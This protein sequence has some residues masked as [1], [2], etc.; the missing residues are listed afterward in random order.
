MPGFGDSAQ[1]F[2]EHG[3]LGVD[4]GFV[5][6]LTGGVEFLVGDLEEFGEVDFLGAFADEAAVK[7][8]FGGVAFFLDEAFEPQVNGA[9]ADDD[10]DV[11]GFLAGHA[12]DAVDGLDEFVVGPGVG[13]ED[14]V[15][16]QVKAVA[17]GHALDAGEHDGS[18]FV[19][20]VAPFLE[21]G[22]VDAAFFL[23]DAAVQLDVADPGV[24][25][26]AGQVIERIVEGAKH[27][28]LFLAGEDFFDEGEATGHFGDVRLAGAGRQGQF[29]VTVALDA[30]R[31]GGNPVEAR[32]GI[33]FNPGLVAIFGNKGSGKS[34]LS[35]TLGLLGQV[36]TLMR[37]IS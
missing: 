36:R 20:G 13:D 26:P 16:G 27:D 33:L 9:V 4:E 7:D 25:K 23:A 35:D 28:D 5:Y 2:A 37:F 1:F 3:P 14:D 6:G 31:I 22:G 30:V 8:K 15:V 17:F 18:R 12:M 29:A 21:F 10:I 11:D 19:A 24:G 34:A 32:N